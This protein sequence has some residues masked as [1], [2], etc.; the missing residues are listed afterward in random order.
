MWEIWEIVLYELSLLQGLRNRHRNH[1][2]NRC[3]K[4]KNLENDQSST[5]V[6]SKTKTAKML[7]LLQQE[8][9]RHDKNKTYIKTK[10]SVF[11]PWLHSPR[12]RPAPCRG[13]PWAWSRV[14]RWRPGYKRG[15]VDISQWIT[16]SKCG[17]WFSFCLVR[18]IIFDAWKISVT[19]WA[20][21]CATWW[22]GPRPLQKWWF[23][24]MLAYKK[25]T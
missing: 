3:K 5:C 23:V 17:A 25:K 8:K 14:S 1:H 9:T 6:N 2:T 22:T 18:G 10:T 21:W 20:S 13:P 7:G 19:V 12:H 24:V 11:L 15:Q 16:Y 4:I